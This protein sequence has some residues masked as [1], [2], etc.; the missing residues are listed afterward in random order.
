MSGFIRSNF[1]LKTIDDMGLALIGSQ[2]VAGSFLPAAAGGLGGASTSGV[3][4]GGFWVM[5]FASMLSGVGFFQESA[6]GILSRYWGTIVHPAGSGFKVLPLI[7]QDF[8]GD[9]VS[10]PVFYHTSATMALASVDSIV[11]IGV[12][13]ASQTVGSGIMYTSASNISVRFLMAGWIVSTP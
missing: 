6:L 10:S 3:I 2:I 7:F 9:G 12:M 8:S 5:S 1:K 11:V 13:K 4:G